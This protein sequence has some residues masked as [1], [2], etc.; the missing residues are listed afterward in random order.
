MDLNKSS[1][2]KWM[3]W[4]DFAPMENADPGIAQTNFLYVSLYYIK[5][6]TL[7]FDHVRLIMSG[8]SSMVGPVWLVQ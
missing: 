5:L 4:N 2:K 8:W 3:V 1:S 6:L 7:Y